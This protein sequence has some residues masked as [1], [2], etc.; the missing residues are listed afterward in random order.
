MFKIE[1]TDTFAGEANY[2]W[3]RRETLD[4]PAGLSRRALVRR[5][6]ALIGWTGAR[7][8]VTDYGGMID[9]RPRGACVVA[10]ITYGEG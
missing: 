3:V 1:M 10:F 9:I 6:K 4:A 2:S 7:C 5:A 8:D